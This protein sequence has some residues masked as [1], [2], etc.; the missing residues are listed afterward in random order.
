[1]TIRY[2]TTKKKAA[3]V[4]EDGPSNHRA[5]DS[6]LLDRSA[7]GKRVVEFAEHPRVAMEV[8]L[9]HIE[10]L[11]CAGYLTA[12]ERMDLRTR[13]VQRCRPWAE[14]VAHE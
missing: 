13:I 12:A 11:A 5:V 8:A 14:E 6:I 10:A 1:V 4:P 2:V 3:P 9:G 7:E